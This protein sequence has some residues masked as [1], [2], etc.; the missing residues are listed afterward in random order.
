MK[1]AKLGGLREGIARTLDT[2]A[3]VA[4]WIGFA[5]MYVWLGYLIYLG[6]HG[7]RI[8]FGD[9]VPMLASLGAGYAVAE[10]LIWLSPMVCPWI[11]VDFEDFDVFGDLED[12][13]MAWLDD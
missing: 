6:A 13:P 5:G 7:A 12:D 8:T 4:I 2:I 9:A 1:L 3:K 10:L 11:D